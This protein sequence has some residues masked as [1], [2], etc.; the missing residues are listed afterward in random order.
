VRFLRFSRIR[1]DGFAPNFFQVLKENTCSLQSA[2]RSNKPGIFYF[3]L[4]SLLMK[5]IFFVRIAIWMHQLS[6]STYFCLLKNSLGGRWMFRVW[7]W[8]LW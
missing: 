4:N 6:A 2:L 1:Q 8:I 5:T 7:S 3:R